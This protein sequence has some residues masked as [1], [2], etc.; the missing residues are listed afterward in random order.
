[1]INTRLRNLK[2]RRTHAYVANVFYDELIQEHEE[3]SERT[4]DREFSH[5]LVA[6]YVFSSLS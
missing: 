6:L 5:N 4:I 2:Y 3:L 1:M